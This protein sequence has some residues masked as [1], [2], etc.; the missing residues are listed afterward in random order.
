MQSGPVFGPPCY[1]RRI[2]TVD[3]PLPLSVVSTKYYEHP[4]KIRMTSTDIKDTN[5]IVTLSQIL[6]NDRFVAVYSEFRIL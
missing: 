6:T 4:V 3:P 2:Y 1:R 5:H